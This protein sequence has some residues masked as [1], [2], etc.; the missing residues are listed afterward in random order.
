MDLTSPRGSEALEPFW[1]RRYG[2]HVHRI[3]ISFTNILC[4][5]HCV[6]FGSIYYGGCFGDGCAWILGIEWLKGRLIALADMAD[7]FQGPLSSAT[8]LR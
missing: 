6:W 4:F 2:Y 1:I 7:H 5:L 3:R 8:P